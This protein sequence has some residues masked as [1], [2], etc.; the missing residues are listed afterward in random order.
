MMVR[1]VTVFGV[2]LFAFQVSACQ[3]SKP[4]A[5]QLVPQ[6]K[7]LQQAKQL[8]SQL[9]HQLDERKQVEDQQQ[10]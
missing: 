9:Q 4:D 10:N 2:L 7:A 5:E 6:R 1:I 8:G 3:P